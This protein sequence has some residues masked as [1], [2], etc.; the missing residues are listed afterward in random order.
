MIESLDNDILAGVV[1]DAG[2]IQIGD[3]RDEFYLKLVNHPKILA[4]SHVAYSTDV[5]DREGNEMMI[6]NIILFRRRAN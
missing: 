3:V 4:T 6:D 2:S 5:T 1:N